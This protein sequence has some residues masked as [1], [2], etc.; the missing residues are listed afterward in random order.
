MMIMTSPKAAA[1]DIGSNTIRLIVP[2]PK[3]DPTKRFLIR[4]QRTRLGQGLFKSGKLD[5]QAVRK[6]I[7][8][9][10]CYT[11]SALNNGA[12]YILAGATSAVREAKNGSEFIKRLNLELGNKG[13]KAVILSEKQ[14][15]E[16]SAHGTMSALKKPLPERALIFDLGGR[17]IEM[18]LINRGKIL[19]SISLNLGAVGLTEMFFNSDIPL[20]KEISD[21]K[22]HIT[23]ILNTEAGRLIKNAGTFNNK[24]TGEP[25]T[26]LAGSAGTV[27]TLAAMVQKMETYNPEKIQNFIINYKQI[28]ALSRQL[29]GLTA[30]KRA[31]LPGLP[32]DRADII[33]A[34]T[35]IVLEIMTHFGS[36]KLIASD[37]GLL[38]GLLLAAS[39]RR[40]I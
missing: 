11:E 2:S 12:D 3:G 1:I 17:S 33:I 7:K 16:L 32:R 27:T 31:E 24:K 4:Q 36:D 26:V 6:S 22:E 5:P 20:Q 18:V 34:G 19:E 35:I 14:E 28:E 9:I 23:N 15:A 25:Q 21:I 37:A 38:E 10:S 29:M 8:V 13:L 30:L 39:G 40:K